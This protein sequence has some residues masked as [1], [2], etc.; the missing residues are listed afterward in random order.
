MVVKSTR[1]L[2]LDFRGLKGIEPVPNQTKFQDQVSKVLEKS[3][4]VWNV[5]KGFQIL[6]VYQEDSGRIFQLSVNNTSGELLL[7]AAFEDMVMGN[8]PKRAFD[9]ASPRS[10]VAADKLKGTGSRREVISAD[11]LPQDHLNDLNKFLGKSFLHQEVPAAELE[12]LMDDAKRCTGILTTGWQQVGSRMEAV[13]TNSERYLKE[14]EELLGSIQAFRR[15]LT[16]LKKSIGEIRGRLKD[17]ESRRTSIQKRI[18]FHK[19]KPWFRLP[20]KL[21]VCEEMLKKSALVSTKVKTVDLKDGKVG[22]RGPRKASP[23]RPQACQVPGSQ[24]KS[25]VSTAD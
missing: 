12:K 9:R 15:T 18:W 2:L 20:P 22:G 16:D 23:H 6:D 13:H 14:K 17:S 24:P 21:I 3:Y 10:D 4:R 5:A 25:R 7:E 19:G 1:V 8:Q 11:S